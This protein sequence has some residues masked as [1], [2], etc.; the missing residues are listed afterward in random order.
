MRLVK[1]NKTHK[2]YKEHR[3]AWAFRFSS[4]D[5]KR[6]P[7]IERIMHDM[8]GSQFSYYMH[9]P[10]WKAGFG[11]ISRRTGYRTYWISFINESDASM[12]LL[13]LTDN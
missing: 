13:Q 12:V 4:Y 1:L 9:N 10:T 8:H 3:H 5:A 11:S 7:K 2:A 6:C